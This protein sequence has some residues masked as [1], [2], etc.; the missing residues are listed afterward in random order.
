MT[1][2]TERYVLRGSRRRARRPNLLACYYFV[3]TTK[4]A[5]SIRFTQDNG[6]GYEETVLFSSSCHGWLFV[7][8]LGH[9]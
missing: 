9:T 5:C 3:L 6:G 4:S 1:E 2:Q 7:G 8:S